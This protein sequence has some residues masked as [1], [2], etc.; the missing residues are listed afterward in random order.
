M[1]YQQNEPLGRKL[2]IIVGLTVVGVMAFG[3]AVSF[4]RNVLFEKTLEDISKGN[5]QLRERIEEGY[6]TLEYHKSAQYK[7]KYAKEN[8]GLVNANEKVLIIS[9]LQI[10]PILHDITIR[11]TEQQEAA[12]EELLR[13]MPVTEHWRLFF[14]H[15]DRI[16][17]I[18]KSL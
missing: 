14:F 4:Y 6:R 10:D 13:Q 2:T 9:E 16:E 17:Q 8:L 15:K 5:V 12:Y 1:S 18:K 7:D 3:L 11:P